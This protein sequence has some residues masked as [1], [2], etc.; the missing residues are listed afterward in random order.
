VRHDAP[1]RKKCTEKIR[2]LER[3]IKFLSPMK[4]QSR[5]NRFDSYLAEMNNK[6]F[7]TQPIAFGNCNDVMPEFGRWQDVQRL[8]GIKRGTLYNLTNAGL[9]KSVTLR[10]KGMKQGCRLY[11]LQSVSEYLHKLMD[12][13]NPGDNFDPQI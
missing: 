3:H 12:E 2:K 6:G 1:R 7:T 5:L 13:Q 9:V 11:Y 10:R 4:P 8:F